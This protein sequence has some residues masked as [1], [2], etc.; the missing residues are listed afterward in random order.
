MPRH[1]IGERTAH[2]LEN[3]KEFCGSKDSRDRI[4]ESSLIGS[5]WVGTAGGWG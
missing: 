3:F 5:F 2:D 4:S 1:Y